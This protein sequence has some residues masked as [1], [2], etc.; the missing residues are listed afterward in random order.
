MGAGLWNADMLLSEKALYGLPFLM[1]LFAA[2]T[3]QKNT[4][5]ISLLKKQKSPSKKSIALK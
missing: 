1:S 5:D 3:V 4:R 2:I